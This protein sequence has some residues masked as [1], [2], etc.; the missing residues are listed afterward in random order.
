[1]NLEKIMEKWNEDCNIHITELAKEDIKTPQLHNKYLKILI[2]E[3]AALFKLKDKSKRAK[4]MLWQYYSGDLNDEPD[5]LKE[6]GREPMSR[7]ILKA[8]VDTWIDSDTDM[9]DILLQVSFQGEKVDY[10]ES[11]LRMINSRGWQI[12]NAI[13]WIKFQD[14]R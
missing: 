14:G 13:E 10:L 11:V 1:M 3:R 12:K 5:T 8:D 6:L 9:I 2:G 4:R 7:R